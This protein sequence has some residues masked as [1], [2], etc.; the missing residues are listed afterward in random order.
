LEEPRIY[1]F[2]NFSGNK[3]DLD[4]ISYL[5]LSKPMDAYDPVRSYE[6]GDLIRA[7]SRTYE[8]KDLPVESAPGPAGGQVEWKAGVNTQYVTPNDMIEVYDKAYIYKGPNSQPRADIT[9]EVTDIFGNSVPLGNKNIP[10]LDEPVELAHSP[11]DPSQQLVHSLSLA[12]LP[13]GRYYLNLSGNRI[14]TF[15]RLN[16]KRHPRAF[17]VA[18]FH[19]TPPGGG[20]PK[21]TADFAFVDSGPDPAEQLSISSPKVYHLRFKNR[22]TFWRYLSS[23][24]QSE[25]LTKQ[26]PL[27]MQRTYFEVRDDNNVILPHP[28]VTR[29]SREIDD[30]GKIEKEKFYSQIYI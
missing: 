27:P 23:K 4:D 10:G 15:Y 14:D 26:E 21:V 8:V 2:D 6:I 17:A 13:T 29:I 28:T 19:Y 1:V 20:N 12:N 16:K 30:T 22:S 3:L 9:F 11:Q 7:N 25:I 18:E 5:F 24:D